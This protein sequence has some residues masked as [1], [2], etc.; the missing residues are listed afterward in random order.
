MEKFSERLKFLIKQRRMTIEGFGKK[1]GFT[2]QGVYDVLKRGYAKPELLQKIC[3][4]LGVNDDYFLSKDF[5]L[6][7][8]AIP[9]FNVDVSASK[10]EMYNDNP[11]IPSM[12][13]VIPGFEDCDFAVPIWGHSMYPTFESGSIIICKKIQS[14]NVIQ[15][16][17]CYLVITDEFRM[18]KRLLTCKEEKN[19]KAV[20]DNEELRKDGA[21]KYD[22][23]EVPKESIRHLY[24]VKG[25][26]K[27][28]QI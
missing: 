8:R 12:Q 6:E 4:V 7:K 11:E 28:Y 18:V 22:S 24:M 5:T 1:I 21:R 27:R 13:V 26:I 2:R 25:C 9:F 10:V 23:F 15:L 17:E 3:K 19:I 20:S 16:G 14:L